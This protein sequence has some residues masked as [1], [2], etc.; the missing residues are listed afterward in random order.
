MKNI[1]LICN[2]HID[3]V[4]QWE[5]EEGAASAISTFRVAADICEE[6]GDF[7]FCHNEAIL[8]R[9][10][11]EYEPK[12][13]RRIQKL[14]SE[15][16]WHIMGGWYLQPDCNMPSGEGFVRNILAGRRYFA[17]K[18]AS[19]PTTAINLDPFGHTRGLVQILAKSGFDSYMFCRPDSGQC[20]LPSECFRWV[21]YDG[22]SV[23]AQRIAFGYN[24]GLGQAA[25]KIKGVIEAQSKGDFATDVGLVLWGIG[26]HGGGPS[27]IDVAAISAFIPQAKNE[28]NNV[29][30]STPERYFAERAEKGVTATVEKG[31]NPCF[32]GCYTSQIRVKQKYRRLEGELFAAERMCA[33]AA[34]VGRIAYPKAELD[35]ALYDLL[36]VQF[37][38]SLP[39]T[40]I[41]PVEEMALRMMDHG[42]EY[43]SRV[44]A[45]AFFAL[46]D[47]QRAAAPDEIPIFAYNP[48]PYPVEGD[49]ECEFMLWDQ[50]WKDEFSIP[51]VFADNKPLLS[52]CEKEQS[53]LSLDWRKR[54]VFHAVLPPS[55]LSRFDC[56]IDVVPR[57][58]EPL[59]PCSTTHFIFSGAN[60]TVK[61]NRLTGLID[62][63]TS[64]GREYLKPG[65]F[66][67]DVMGD[68]S[69]PW[70]MRTL[71]FT[72]KIGEFSLLSEREGSKYSNVSPD[73]PS[74]R[75]IEDG[76]VRD[77]VEAV[78]GYEHSYAVVRYYLS[79]AGKAMGLSI[80]VNWAEKSKMLKLAIPAAF[81]SPA[82]VG[83]TAFG[84]EELKTDGRENVSQRWIRL[85][86]G[87]NALAAANDGVYGSSYHDGIL[88]ITLLRSP[89]Y[90]VHPIGDRPLMPQDRFSPYM[91]Q[92]E[93]RFRFDLYAGDAGAVTESISRC[94]DGLNEPPSLLSFFPCG[95]GEKPLPGAELTGSAAIEMPAFKYAEDGSGC[96]ARLFNP[97]E[98]AQTACLKFAPFNINEQLTLMP[99]EIKTVRLTASGLQVCGLNEENEKSE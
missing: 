97:L 86:D 13:F 31:L 73:I 37:H 34:A 10:V 90:T 12:L 69:D 78:F 39:G 19:R 45:R 24:S 96:I 25:N 76:D 51:R 92:G 99:Y 55:R 38:D 17:E 36:T 48:H 27:K 20:P 32:P 9:W 91:E 28:G 30:H 98:S 65:A 23:I 62:S 83:E 21:G 93:R 33:H 15:G 56:K 58:P 66:R 54:V 79:K 63:Y 57:K 8:Y 14:V 81:A 70:E 29:F 47:G 11:E 16:K 49:F 95:E 5:W 50:N 87:E 43:I 53:N 80:R 88:Y 82:V 2:A 84:S 44:R 77:V 26:D 46:A 52:Q 68:S 4:W 94:A 40:S 61:I 89:G 41:Q 42:L 64:G 75:I 72:N 6:N 74:V 22:S 67:L 1:H 35:Q 85:S 59:M 60:Y 3:P 71:S 18:F 7:V